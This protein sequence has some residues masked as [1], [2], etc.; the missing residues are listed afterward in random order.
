MG[1]GFSVNVAEVRVHS[2]TVAACAAQVRSA[3]GAAQSVSDGAYGVIGQFFASAILSACGDV[4]QGIAKV[5]TAVDDVREGL[6]AVA[7]QYSSIE[8]DITATLSGKVGA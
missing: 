7:D 2:R 1:N 8:A 4:V 5:A 6:Q 3:T